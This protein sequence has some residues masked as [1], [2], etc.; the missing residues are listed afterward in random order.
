M[1]LAGPAFGLLAG[2][3][4][5]KVCDSNT[6]YLQARE[7]PPLQMPEGVPGSERIGSATLVIPAVAPVPDKLEPAPR[8]L[9]EPPGFFKRV[10]G[11][12]PA[13]AP[14]PPPAPE[15]TKKQ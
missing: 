8:C 4:S 3:A 11:P 9:D 1:I 7:R 15:A 2:C 13:P 10:T 12:A 6:E 14:A 5:S